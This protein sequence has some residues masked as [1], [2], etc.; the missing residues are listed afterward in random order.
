MSQCKNCEGRRMVTRGSLD[1]GR[2]RWIV[3]T[4]CNGAGPVAKPSCHEPY[5]IA[6]SETLAELRRLEERALNGGLSGAEVLG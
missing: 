4:S 3:C 1:D 6:N 2:K 5:D